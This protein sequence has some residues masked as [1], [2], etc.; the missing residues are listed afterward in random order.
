MKYFFSNLL[1]IDAVVAILL[2]FTAFR[3]TGKKNV[4]NL[5][6]I[7]YSIASAIWSLGFGMLF[8]CEDTTSAYFWRS[9]GIMGT[10]A[11]MFIA[12][13]LVCRISMI[14][15]K[16]RISLD[17]VAS[18]GIIVFFL[19][20]RPGQTLFFM[21]DFGMTY[22]FVPGI[23]NA[24]YTTYFALVSANILGVIIY[25]ILFSKLKRL[26]RFGIYFLIVT[27][28]IL[29][30]TV[31][32]MI[33]PAIGLPA[34]PGSNVTQFWGLIIIYYAMRAINQ[35]RINVAN[36]S[37]YVYSLLPIPVMIL[38][39]N[40][41]LQLYNDAAVSFLKLPGKKSEVTNI[42]L[43][44][45]FDLPSELLGYQGTHLS[46]DAICTK[47]R[48]PCNLNISKISDTYGDT[49]GYFIL[50]TDLSERMQYIHALEIA[51]E[52]A[53]AS[54]RAKSQFL[55]NMSHEIRTPM[56]AIIGFSELA[57]QEHNPADLADYLRDIKNASHNLMSLIN[58]VLDFSKIESGKMTLVNVPYQLADTLHDICQMIQQQTGKKNLDFEV[59]ISPD[60]PSRLSGDVSRLQS[61]LVNLLSNAVKY[62]PTGFVRLAV[63]AI[64]TAENRVTLRIRVSDSGIGIKEEEIATL[65]DAFTQVDQFTNYG[66]EGT[67]LGLA[68]VK[69]ICSLMGGEVSVEST[70]G[71]GSTFTATVVQE[72]LDDTPI[73]FEEVSSLAISDE[74]TLG[75]LRVRN[76]PVLV[77]DDNSINRK[78][79]SRSLSY[80]GMDVDV[81]SGGIEAIEMCHKKNYSIVFMDQM[82]P[83]MDGIEAMKAIREQ[84]PYYAPGAPGKIV[85]L[86]ANAITQAR[87]QLLAEG[88]D[89]YMS[90]PIVY[91]EL[92]TLL[93]AYIPGEY[94]VYDTPE[95]ISAE[96]N[97][98][99]AISQD[100]LARLLPSLDVEEGLHHCG[101][102]TDYLEILQLVHNSFR[103]SLNQL[104]DAQ[105]R[106]HWKDF[107][108]Y[109][110]A[111][112][113]SCLNIGATDCAAQARVLEFAGKNEET[114]VIEQT[115]AQF[116]ESYRSLMSEIKQALIS[117]HRTPKT[118]SSSVPA[119]DIQA[120]LDRFG[121]AIDQMDFAN[122]AAMLR[123]AKEEFTGTENQAMFSQLEQLLDQMDMDKIL[124]LISPK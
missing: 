105:Q 121:S 54:N 3:G 37:G 94:I 91:P 57:L 52:E 42:T 58:D 13:A 114:D 104:Q 6:L 122:A 40:G 38:D 120:F 41:F 67:G 82:M 56:N 65:F 5:F 21:S 29:V 51:R 10:I 4:E 107:A 59:D 99:I 63:D 95:D 73:H 113:G 26:R 53:D 20:T 14:P 30:G 17:F 86:T 84:E 24:I 12:Q 33:F 109:A 45:I 85:C 69:G 46:L 83:E 48:I 72:V 115:T 28:L 124:Q 103:L 62:T 8:L 87:A 68:L 116:M 23:I 98:S 75:K 80:Y 61:L 47:N 50:V 32:D 78:V 19:S 16:V 77:V 119:E 108:T 102:L 92:E 74:Y 44:D 7:L 93:L 55:A 101:D 71:K 66:I 88:F 97:S 64:D 89:E 123:Q 49:I 60:L 117:L 111:I 39:W 2:I 9:F 1:V 118:P 106:C 15:I 36:M 31:L 25:M 100:Q 34:L 112:K 43:R 90:K 70:Y 11:Y 27:I 110:H 81:A 79:I 76:V 96:K 35:N 22:Q 18:L